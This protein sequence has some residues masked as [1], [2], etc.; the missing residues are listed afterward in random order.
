MTHL[1]QIAACADMH[2]AISKH[3]RA[4]RTHT[5]V[6]K[7]DGAEREREVGRMIAGAAVSAT[8]LESARE[9]LARGK[10]EQTNEHVQAARNRPAE[11]GELGV[12]RKFFIET[13]GCQM[14]YHDSERIAACS[15]R[16][17]WS[18]ST[19]DADADVVVLNT[20]SVRE[21]A[22]EKLYSRLGE[23]RDMARE[24]GTDPVI[25]VAGCVAQ[26]EG[27]RLLK[28]AGDRRRHRRHSAHQAVAGTRPRCDASGGARSSTSARLMTCRFRLASRGTATRSAPG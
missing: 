10:G 27:E 17:A 19:R 9:L 16:T 5:E 20:C 28:R 6:V 24:Q 1:A 18:P 22:E 15:S 23:L 25:V 13:F 4:G 21:R 26:Q 3:V 11:P 2:F 14:N 12:A 8:V 7:L